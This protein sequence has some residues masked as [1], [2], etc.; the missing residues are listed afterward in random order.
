MESTSNRNRKE[1]KG[2]GG[3]G[4]QECL[5]KAAVYVKLRGQGKLREMQREQS[6]EQGTGG[7]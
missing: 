2:R 7:K 6:K 4:R 1:G 3:K 5:P